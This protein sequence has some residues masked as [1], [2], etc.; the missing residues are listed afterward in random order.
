MVADFC[1]QRR[2]LTIVMAV[3]DIYVLDFVINIGKPISSI[4]RWSLD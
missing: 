3:L 4:K 2:E 1:L